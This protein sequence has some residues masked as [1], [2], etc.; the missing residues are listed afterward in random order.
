M[1]SGGSET[2]E[3]DGEDSSEDAHAED[4]E[5]QVDADPSQPGVAS[6][7]DLPPDDAPTFA[8]VRPILDERVNRLRRKLKNMGSVNTDSL[9][10]LDELES[11]HGHLHA[12]LQDLVEARTTLEEI[13]RRINNESKRLF[14][15][16]FDQVRV[17]FQ[18]LFRRAF[19]GGDGD[20]ILEN[21]EDVLDCGIDI[22]ARPPGKEL[23]SILLMSGGEKTLT[24][25]ALLLAIFQCRPSPYCVLDEVDAALD[26]AN[27]ERLTSLLQEFEQKTQFLIVT[28]KKPTMTICDAI[29]GVTMEEAG[30]SKR[31][32]VRFEDVRDNG[33]VVASSRRDAA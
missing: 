16:T 25:F 3:V 21:P 6:T 11:R 32:S 33:E 13:I 18:R 14:L 2:G 29:Y 19:G 24:A 22:V 7:S 12:Q 1:N 26:E 4:N 10:D 20:V 28:H 31:I 30:V 8:E 9:R 23:K 5:S 15:E 27:V 17:N